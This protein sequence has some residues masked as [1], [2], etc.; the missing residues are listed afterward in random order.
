MRRQKCDRKD[1]CTRCV[2][3]NVASSCTQ[4]WPHDYDPKIH[5]SYPKS[6]GVQPRLQVLPPG[7]VIGGREPQDD[8]RDASLTQDITTIQNAA[9]TNGPSPSQNKFQSQHLSTQR[10]VGRILTNDKRKEAS[11]GPRLSRAGI[12]P[13]SL[14]SLPTNEILKPYYSERNS[15]QPLRGPGAGSTSPGSHPK[16]SF[17]ET[18]PKTIERPY[19]QTLLPTAR[20]ILQLVDYHS[21]CLLWYHRCLHGP[22]FRSELLKALEDP[23]GLLL[24][25]LD[26][27]WCAILFAI[28]A[29]SLTC[30]TDDIARSWGFSKAEKS[31][32]CREWY[33]ATISCLYLADY[34]SNIH[35]Y[36]IQAIQTLSMAAHI[37]GFSNEQFVYLGGAI[38]IA[39]SLGLQRL[40]YDIEVDNAL[41][42]GNLMSQERKDKLTKREMGRRIW[43][44]LCTQDWFSTP[45]SDMYFINKLHF[46]TLKPNRFDD[47]TMSLVDEDVPVGTDFGHY[48]YDIAA[49]AADFH[50]A[51]SCAATLPAKY[52][53]VLKY[54]S[55]MRAIAAEAMPQSLCFTDATENS[56]PQWARWARSTADIGL[57]HKLIMLHRHFLAKSFTD[58]RFA[59]TRWASIAA[60]KT[61]LR[62]VEIATA[63]KARPIL[64]TDQV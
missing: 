38:R 9:T 51:V 44:Q 34:T 25:R 11:K 60:S 31:N 46:T 35:V 47:E 49:V 6:K 40:A 15:F 14:E 28:M 43:A 39:Q 2:Q 33:S 17:A 36:S 7:S 24:K 56:K 50:D 52:E 16:V 10:R 4:K 29:S 21:T 53:E 22:T 1:P 54:D 8:A 62:E 32:L 64:W 59:Y 41:V 55:K 27:Q 61:I 5:R 20:Q 26:L 12:D 13:S 58:Q 30:A 57:A 48:V 18:C 42:D 37:L 3:S 63:D 23:D 19:L 45:A